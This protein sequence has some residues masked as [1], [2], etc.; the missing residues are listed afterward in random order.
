MLTG[1]K[2]PSKSNPATSEQIKADAIE[3]TVI[4]I[5]K[6]WKAG[7][8]N[9]LELGEYF[10]KLRKL[11]EPYRHDKDGLSY[12]ASV[13]RTGVP[14]GT[15][16]SYR[17]MWDAK[18]ACEISTD[19]FLVLCEE[20][21]NLGIIR[22]NLGGAFK[23]AVSEFLGAFENVHATDAKSVKELARKMKGRLIT[24]AA[25]VTESEDEIARLEEDYSDL[26]KDIDKAVTAK[27]PEAAADFAESLRVTREEL[28]TAQT[29]RMESLVDSI[30]PFLEWDDE[31][32][33]KYITQFA[34][35]TLPQ[36]S[37][38]YKNAV[39]LLKSMSAGL[40]SLVEPKPKASE[41]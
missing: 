19:L 4:E 24:K 39:K 32:I 29:E 27:N 5:R 30:A 28:R 41:K 31:A 14:R 9:R 6:L 35:L 38:A 20:G 33:E 21:V 18:E 37:E 1:T 3:Q 17:H 2:E 22:E 25:K 40:R 8:D 16:E 13:A 36:Q 26:L 12:A 7:A 11:T 34:E 10:S 15:A 23:G